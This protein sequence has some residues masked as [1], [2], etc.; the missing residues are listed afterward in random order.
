MSQTM[1]VLRSSGLLEYRDRIHALLSV[2]GFGA[3]CCSPPPCRCSF[4]MKTLTSSRGAM[5]KCWDRYMTGHVPEFICPLHYRHASVGGSSWASRARTSAGPGHVC[6][7][8]LDSD[9]TSSKSLARPGADLQVRF[10]EECF[11]PGQHVGCPGARP[12]PP[13]PAPP[14]FS[15]LGGGDGRQLASLRPPR[16]RQGPTGICLRR[17]KKEQREAFAWGPG[18]PWGPRCDD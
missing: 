14:P 10:I 12:A 5:R 2:A 8:K 17:R 15:A 7:M 18:V 16:S 6:E 4:H 9:E 13:R 3:T 1:N 11:L